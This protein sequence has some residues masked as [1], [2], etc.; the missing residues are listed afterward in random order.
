MQF[1]QTQDCSGTFPHPEKVPSCFGPGE[2]LYQ[3]PEQ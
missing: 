1:P 2:G 3:A